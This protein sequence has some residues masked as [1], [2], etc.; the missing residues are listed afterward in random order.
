MVEKKLGDPV[1]LAA[2]QHLPIEGVLVG[3]RRQF[4]GHDQPELGAGDRLSLLVDDLAGDDAELGRIDRGQLEVDDFRLR[5]DLGQDAAESRR[6]EILSFDGD[7]QRQAGHQIVEPELA[8]GCFEPLAAKD[9]RTAQVALRIT[10][11]TIGRKRDANP[12]L[13]ERVPLAAS[14]TRPRTIPCDG[15]VTTTSSSPSSSSFW[16]WSGE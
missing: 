2:L 10:G 8:V 12:E 15:M 9:R 11:L 3:I 4:V 13:L 6:A 1:D 7:L 5:L 14:R 16:S